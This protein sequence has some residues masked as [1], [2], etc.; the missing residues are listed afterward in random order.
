MDMPE[1]RPQGEPMPPTL[2]VNPRS[3]VVLTQRA[4]TLV[5]NR[6]RTPSELEAALRDRYPRVR[7]RE[8]SLSHESV[9]VWYVYREGSWIPSETS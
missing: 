1:G 3:D 9:A 7:V 6:A 2:M 5:L 8:R 4:T